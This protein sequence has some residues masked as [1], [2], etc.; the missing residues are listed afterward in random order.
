MSEQKRNYRSPL[1]AQQAAAT[2]RRVLES[3]A[4]VFGE[5]GYAGTT[6]AAIAARADVSVE[7][8]KANGQKWAL[9]LAAYELA[10]GGQEGEHSAR[11]ALADL[12]AVAPRAPAEIVEAMLDFVV[13]GNERSSLLWLAFQAAVGADPAL[14]DAL[15]ELI[16]RRDDDLAFTVTTLADRGWTPRAGRDETALALGYLIAPESHIHFVVRG[17]WS[18]AKYRSW[19]ETV[20]RGLFEPD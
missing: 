6:L 8:V 7:T 1:R 20:V 12:D 13:E 10:F 9:M 2:R 11:D 4:A 5:R 18:V 3:A 15:D 17:G 19:L 16:R 14:A